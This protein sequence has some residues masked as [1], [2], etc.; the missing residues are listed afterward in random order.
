MIGRLDRLLAITGLPRV[1]LGIVPAASEIPFPPTNFSMFDNTTVLVEGVSAEL[2]IT[3]PREIDVYG[4]AFDTLAEVSVTG[5][6]ARELI[7]A[8]LDRRRNKDN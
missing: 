1:T 5:E 4:R 6:D 8:A 3:Q 7:R 2:T